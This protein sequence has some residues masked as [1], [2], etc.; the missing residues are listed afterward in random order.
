MVKLCPECSAHVTE[1]HTKQGTYY[2]GF[3]DD[4]YDKKVVKDSNDNIK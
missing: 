4:Y 1:L 2:C 3:C